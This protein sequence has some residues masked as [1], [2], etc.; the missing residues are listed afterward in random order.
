MAK[1]TDLNITNI[2]V[3]INELINRH[4]LNRNFEKLLDNDKKLAKLID[5]MVQ[6]ATTIKE[7]YPGIAYTKG[8]YVWYKTAYKGKVQLFLLQNLIENNSNEPTLDDDTETA[9]FRKSGWDNKNELK[10]VFDNSIKEYVGKYVQTRLLANHAYNTKYHRYG[11][12]K[13][14]DEAQDKILLADISNIKID[15]KTKFYP[16]ETVPLEETNSVV[17]GYYRRWDNGLLEYDITFKLGYTGDTEINGMK[18]QNIVCNNLSITVEDDAKYFMSD[19][20]KTIFQETDKNTLSTIIGDMVQSNRNKLVNVYSATVDFPLAFVDTNY[21]IF[22]S[23]I[24]QQK[25]DQD[26][27]SVDSGSNTL[28]YVNRTTSSISPIYITTNTNSNSIDAVGLVSNTFHCQI[29]GRW[30]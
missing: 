22:A 2:N 16:Y 5:D 3:S 20:D 6:S 14:D 28:T 19:D 10:S 7:Y 26:K 12:L 17:D 30:K 9:S 11:T 27:S 23:D 24:T 29:V 15:R 21:M 25:R 13:D 1:Y 4:T 18:Y 8:I